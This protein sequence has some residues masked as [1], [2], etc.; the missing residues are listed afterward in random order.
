MVRDCKA[1]GGQCSVATMMAVCGASSVVLSRDRAFQ[2]ECMDP[3]PGASSLGALQGSLLCW[4][5]T[6]PESEASSCLSATMGNPNEPEDSGA[7]QPPP[8]NSG[9]GKAP[10]ISGPESLELSISS[11]NDAQGLGGPGQQPRVDRSGSGV[12]QHIGSTLHVVSV[13]KEEGCEYASVD[14]GLKQEDL[15]G[16][17]DREG[18]I[19]PPR[20]RACMENPLRFSLDDR[21]ISGEYGESAARHS[22]QTTTSNAGPQHATSGRW[23]PSLGMELRPSSHLGEQSSKGRQQSWW[24]TPNS[25]AAPSSILPLDRS[26]PAARNLSLEGRDARGQMGDDTSFGENLLIQERKGERGRSFGKE[27]KNFFK[28]PSFH[29]HMLSN[30]ESKQDSPGAQV[31]FPSS[32]GVRPTLEPN[33]LE[34]SFLFSRE[35]LGTRSWAR[36]L[37]AGEEDSTLAAS[38]PLYS[39]GGHSSVPEI[40]DISPLEPREQPGMRNTAFLERRPSLSEASQLAGFESKGGDRRGSPGLQVPI[41][42][43]Q[44]NAN[45]NFYARIL[46]AMPELG[47]SQGP[48]S[49]GEYAQPAGGQLPTLNCDRLNFGLSTSGLPSI[50]HLQPGHVPAQ[51]LE[52]SPQQGFNLQQANN[53]MLARS[54]LANAQPINIPAPSFLGSLQSTDSSRMNVP[55]FSSLDFLQVIQRSSEQR[56]PRQGMPQNVAQSPPDFGLSGPFPNSHYGPLPTELNLSLPPQS[57]QTR[58]P[59]SSSSLRDFLTPTQSTFGPPSQQRYR[60]LGG[61]VPHGVPDMRNPQLPKSLQLDI[62]FPS[63]EVPPSVTA[64]MEGRSIGQRVSLH[65][66]SGYDSFARAM[67]RMFED[68]ITGASPAATGQEFH[69]ANAI[70]GYVIAYEDEEGDLLLAG[71]LSWR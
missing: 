29:P 54:L 23:M 24:L 60:P 21:L 27:T 63:R 44:G 42:N 33:A 35:S 51:F 40:G 70:P 16:V 62:S 66:Y 5:V 19:G 17:A 2:H 18:V 15:S 9:D 8:W 64:V 47:T 55:D 48:N 58:L 68:S 3:C 38:G 12:E 1:V 32:G 67:R 7:S 71:D 10:Q 49:F 43:S 20:K 13:L 46:G 57:S 37:S 34:H 14:F 52:G 53:D 26:E 31:M 36:N 69:L 45:T 6:K 41:G 59:R 50:A 30:F 22:S 56:F 4:G 61:F 28:L 65:D 25:V 39:R 11:L